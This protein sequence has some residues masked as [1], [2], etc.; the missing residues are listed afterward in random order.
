MD[1][2]HPSPES[3][4]RMDKGPHGE[5]LGI[6]EDE[7]GSK[8]LQRKAKAAGSPHWVP[9][10][11][12]EARIAVAK[13]QTTKKLVLTMS[14]VRAFDLATTLRAARELPGYSTAITA[15][16]LK[17]AEFEKCAYVAHIAALA[18]QSGFEVAFIP[19]STEPGEKTA[20]L[21]ISRDGQDIE[22]ECKRKEPATD[23]IWPDPIWKEL[24]AA[25]DTLHGCIEESYEVVTIVI[26]SLLRHQIAPVASLSK[27]VLTKGDQGLYTGGVAD[28]AVLIRRSPPAPPGVQGLWIP[29]SQNPATARATVRVD[30]QGK[31]VYGPQLRTTLYSIRSH[32]LSQ[33]LSSF[34]T[35]RKQLR[36]ASCGVIYI[37]VDGSAIPRGDHP[38]YFDLMAQWLGR[39]FTATQNTRVA[40]VVLTSGPDLGQLPP[41][42][43]GHRTAR[44]IRVIRNSHAATQPRVQL[45]GENATHRRSAGAT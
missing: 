23:P 7:F 30:A 35:A 32:R 11:W 25:L 24:D 12:E 26:G 45:P 36:E 8:W 38:L 16:K 2:L 27:E 4:L 17:G 15:A 9:H 42:G 18:L 13:S 44:F 43:A 20:D 10:G 5:L 14:M 1:R 31:P 34:N 41:E 3:S 29:K 19:T 33:L 6:L 28:C 39:Q 40:A 21:R 37:D 22:V